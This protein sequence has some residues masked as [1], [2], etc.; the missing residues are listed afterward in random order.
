MSTITNIGENTLSAKLKAILLKV[1]ETISQRMNIHQE[2]FGVGRDFSPKN[3]THLFKEI[4]DL[5][6]KHNY[7]YL[8]KIDFSNFFSTM[9]T[10]LGIDIASD[11]NLR[12]PEK[13]S[14][15]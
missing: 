6:H 12:L 10:F 14:A 2:M 8:I 9:V 15:I 4:G 3:I 7:R 13:R 1:K 5:V 11:G